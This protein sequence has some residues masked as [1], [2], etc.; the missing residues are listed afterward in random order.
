MENAVKMFPDFYYATEKECQV[1]SLRSSDF[2]KSYIYRDGKSENFH[3]RFKYYI[4]LNDP[5]LGTI[6]ETRIIRSCPV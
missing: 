6:N 4:Y 1:K 3:R 5:F 2:S